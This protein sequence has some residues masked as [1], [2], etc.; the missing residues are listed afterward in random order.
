M[1]VLVESQG[2]NE[3]VDW[4]DDGGVGVVVAARFL[5]FVD[6]AFIGRHGRWQQSQ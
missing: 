2:T 6:C 4:M 1:R 5:E 3:G